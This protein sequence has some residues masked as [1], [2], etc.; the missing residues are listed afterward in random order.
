MEYQITSEQSFEQVAKDLLGQVTGG[1]KHP[2]VIVLSGPLGA[3]KTTLVKYLARELGITEM[4]TS[5]TFVIMRSYPVSGDEV[6]YTKLVHM[7]LYRL[8]K[9]EEVATFD[10]RTFVDDKRNLVC[11]EWPE[12]APEHIPTDSVEVH[13]AYDQADPAKRIVTTTY[14]AKEE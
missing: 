10:F 7:D 5:P 11:I 4:I 8:E 2:H 3:G 13:I 9:P 6:F 14:H 12:Q 1:A